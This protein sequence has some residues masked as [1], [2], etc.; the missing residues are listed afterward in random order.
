MVLVLG[1]NM[2]SKATDLWSVNRGDAVSF[3]HCA[4]HD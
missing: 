1:R 3:G 2:K 4:T